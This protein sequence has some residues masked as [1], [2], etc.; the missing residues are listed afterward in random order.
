MEF[1]GEPW[2]R[3]GVRYLKN[4]NNRP[5]EEKLI[6][7]VFNSIQTQEDK[8]A[9]QALRE[10][11]YKTFGAKKG[12]EIIQKAVAK[13]KGFV[14]EKKQKRATFN[15]GIDLEDVYEPKEYQQMRYEEEYG[16]P[17]EIANYSD[18]SDREGKPPVIHC[19]LEWDG[20]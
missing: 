9:R 11:I 20:S 5:N 1:E 17:E 8:A 10:E 19:E 16:T 18:Y 12:E 3:I 6:Q 4:Y 14:D 13:R 2:W 15:F 7:I